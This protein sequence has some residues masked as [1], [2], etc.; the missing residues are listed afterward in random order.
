MD[1]KHSVTLA[2]IRAVYVTGRVT[3][4]SKRMEEYAQAHPEIREFR[5]VSSPSVSLRFLDQLNM[6]ERRMQDKQEGEG[7]F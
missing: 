2:G 1:L 4:D 5:K 7:P 6:P 3:Y